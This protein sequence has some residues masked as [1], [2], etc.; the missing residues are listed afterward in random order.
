M[1]HLLF[2]ALLFAWAPSTWAQPDADEPAEMVQELQEFRKQEFVQRLALTNSEAEAFFPIYDQSQLEIRQARLQ[3]RK[4]W[5]RRELGS[6]TE[7]EAKMY[8]AEAVALRQ[9]E[10]DIHAMYT[11]KLVPIIGYKRVVL[12]PQI[13]REVR[14]QLL[15]K[16]RAMGLPPGP[17]MP[18]PG[19]D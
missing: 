2:V 4:K 12:L 16:A 6:L 13:E 5:G 10:M 1:R 7:E 19:R 8:Y 9:K 18:P 14:S 11:P 15:K 3:F 17:D